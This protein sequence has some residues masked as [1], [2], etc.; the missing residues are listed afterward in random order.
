MTDSPQRTT[1]LR[2]T[3]PI[4]PLVLLLGAC[5]AVDELP[6]ET[7]TPAATASPSVASSASPEPTALAFPVKAEGEIAR[8]EFVPVGADGVPETSLTAED[9][10]AEGTY[11]VEGECLGTRATYALDTAAIDVNEQRRL[12]AGSMSCDGPFR[13]TFTISGYDGV[14]QLRFTDTDLIETGW[15]RVVP[16]P[17]P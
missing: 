14:V 9:A 11:A 2:L 17:A 5:T 13:S 3:L 16:V 8:A 1:I 15:L 6:V 7:H 12:T 10:V 4:L